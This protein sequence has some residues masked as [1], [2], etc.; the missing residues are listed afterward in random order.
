MCSVNA[1]STLSILIEF[2]NDDA[3]DADTERRNAKKKRKSAP[4]FS[5]SRDTADAQGKKKQKSTGT[6]SASTSKD[7]ES[8]DEEEEEKAQGGEDEE[9]NDMNDTD[10]RTPSATRTLDKDEKVGR[11]SRSSTHKSQPKYEEEGAAAMANFFPG[12]LSALYKV[13]LLSLRIR[14]QCCMSARS[15]FSVCVLR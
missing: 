2:F 4:L 6:S 10:E 8:E 1:L 14:F 9:W 11:E 13:P 5:R 3:D 7:E 12:I 15:R